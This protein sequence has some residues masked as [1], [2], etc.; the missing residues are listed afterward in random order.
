MYFNLFPSKKNG[1]EIEESDT[2]ASASSSSNSINTACTSSSSEFHEPPTRKRRR[3]YYINKD[4]ENN[5]ICSSERTEEIHN[6][7]AKM[8]AIN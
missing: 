4:L 3:T 5:R 1:H 8:I 7:L 2:V 6:A